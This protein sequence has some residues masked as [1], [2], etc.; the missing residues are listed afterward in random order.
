M[1][2]PK[3]NDSDKSKHCL[4]WSYLFLHALRQ[5]ELGRACDFWQVAKTGQLW[6]SPRR[7]WY[8]KRLSVFTY[9]FMKW[10]DYHNPRLFT[11]VA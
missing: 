3:L 4:L 10:L 5:K 9:Y 1:L 11:A 6:K 2:F 8:V 7:I